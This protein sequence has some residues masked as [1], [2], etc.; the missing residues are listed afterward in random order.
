MTG[1]ERALR[2]IRGQQTDR[3]SVLPSIDVAYAPECIGQTVGA[4]F[5]DPKLHAI[6]LM[7]ALDRY[8]EIDGLYINLC[9]DGNRLTRQPNGLYND[10]YGLQWYIPEKDVGTVKFHEIEELDDPR[11]E[12]ESSLRFG[13]LETFAAIDPE[14]KEKYLIMPGITGPYSQLVFMMGLENVLMMTY[15]DPEGL[16]EAIEKRVQHS[17]AWLDELITLGAETVWIGEGAASSSVISP[18]SYAEFV[19]PY[20]KAV[21]DAAKQRGIPCFMHVCG[22]IVPSIGEIATTGCSAID[23]DYM[24]PMA[25]VREHLGPEACLKGNLNPM[26]LRAKTAEE[27]FDI[28]RGI[29]QETEGPMILGTGCLVAP[30][31]PTENIEAMVRA[32]KAMAEK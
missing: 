11:M 29:Y 26:E 21:V 22:N 28:C 15:D 16:K 25:L 12:E 32:S 5:R 17:I 2:A 18:A 30:K 10:G 24:V 4:C 14:Y 7:G 19:A 23:I 8:P 27:V 20:A 13:I 9:L 1:K 6:A 3:P 31:T